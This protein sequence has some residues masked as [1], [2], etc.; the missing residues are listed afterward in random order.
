MSIFMLHWESDKI[1]WT[2]YK[3]MQLSIGT[4][5]GTCTEHSTLGEDSWVKFWNMIWDR[6]I[7]FYG[8]NI[9]DRR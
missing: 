7:V 4:I 2:L 9:L 8:K 1:W 6:Q 3:W 5:K